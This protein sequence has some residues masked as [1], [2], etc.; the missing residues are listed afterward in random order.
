M[1]YGYKILVGEPKKKRTQGRPHVYIKYYEKSLGN[2]VIGC[3]LDSSGSEYSG[4][5][6]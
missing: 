3:G 1:K 6:L 2:T 4:A 5:I